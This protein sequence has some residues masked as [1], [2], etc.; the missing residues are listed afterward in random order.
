MP[1]SLLALLCLVPILTAAC[2]IKSQKPS[3]T[4]TLDGE[5]TQENP[6]LV[7]TLETPVL[8]TS[9]TSSPVEKPV[10]TRTLTLDMKLGKTATVTLS[11]TSTNTPTLTMTPTFAILRGEVL[12]RAN[13]RYG[14]GAPYLYKY[15][16]VAGSNLEIIGR[17]DA[18]TWILVQAIGG[19]NPCWMKAS[20]MD[21]KG[22]VMGVRPTTIPLPNSP[23]YGP[24]KRVSAR[25]DGDIVTVFWSPLSLRAGDDSEQTPYVIEAWVCKDGKLIFIPVGAYESA[26]EIR[27]ETGCSEPSHARITAAEKHGYTPFVDIPWP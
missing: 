15:G 16:L 25:R 23:Y 12:V 26:V 7:P 5:V 20:L 21:V 4:Q 10:K 27:D 19:N 8:Y 22:D 17:T 6:I 2:G 1:R 11:R 18:G 9:T 24:L 14:P 13:C 3:V